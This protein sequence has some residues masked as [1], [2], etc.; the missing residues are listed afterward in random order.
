[1][2]LAH[3]QVV[4]LTTVVAHRGIRNSQFFPVSYVQVARVAGE[5]TVGAIRSMIYCSRR[6]RSERVVEPRQNR[7]GVTNLFPSVLILKNQS[8]DLARGSGVRWGFTVERLHQISSAVNRGGERSRKHPTIGGVFH[9]GAVI[10]R[11]R[12]QR[13]GTGG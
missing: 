4:V 3:G 2:G 5:Y 6:M 12:N 1:M 10:A 7:R 9:H 13:D 11:N 8:H